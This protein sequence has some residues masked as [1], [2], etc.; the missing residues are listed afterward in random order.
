MQITAIK[1]KEL[2]LK[3]TISFLVVILVS[4]C[5]PKL[6]NDVTDINEVSRLIGKQF[7]SIVELQVRGVTFGIDG[8]RNVDY[9]YITTP[10]SM[11]GSRV[12]FKG[13][14]PKGVV[15]EIVG[16]V[17]SRV[18]GSLERYYL[19]KV[20]GYPKYNRFNVVIYIDENVKSENLGLNP[21]AYSEQ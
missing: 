4:A 15:F 21:N 1:F 10:P 13:I 19:V 18:Y 17:E 12:V 9:V 11:G 5:T 8:K 3:L 7:R 14:L 2:L 6:Y 20:Q 16:A